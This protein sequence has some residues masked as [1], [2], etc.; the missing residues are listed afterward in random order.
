MYR[1]KHWITWKS[2]KAGTGICVD[3]LKAGPD[4]PPP[5]APRV[6]AEKD[7]RLVSVEIMARYNTA[8][9]VEYEVV[10]PPPALTQLVKELTDAVVKYG[11]LLK[12]EN[13][14]GISHVSEVDEFQENEA[15]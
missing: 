8:L 1:L 10:D 11:V 3:V 9:A 5:G 14:L 15:S 13:V 12:R 7:G 2:D 4:G 6:S